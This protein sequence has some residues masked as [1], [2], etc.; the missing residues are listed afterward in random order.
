LKALTYHMVIEFP[1][2]PRP[3][4]VEHIIVMRDGNKIMAM[5][6]PNLQEGIGGF[7]D[8][9]PEALRDLADAF[10]HGEWRSDLVF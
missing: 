4:G 2:P 8:T 9:I 5:I 3:Q 10:E 7:G 6:G 1:N